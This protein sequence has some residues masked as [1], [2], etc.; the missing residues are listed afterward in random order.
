MKILAITQP[1]SGVGYHR[2]M[3]PLASMQGVKA[4]ATNLFTQEVVNEGYD[5]LYY[6]REAPIKESWDTVREDTG[7]KIAIDI[8]DH[9][10]L[11]PN[12]ILYRQYEAVKYRIINN[13]EQADIVTTTHEAL[14][15][16]IRQYNNNVVVLPNAIPYG[17]DLFNDYKQPSSKVRFF[18]AG[19]VT[20]EPDIALLRNVVKR[21]HGLP[22][23]MVI[24]GFRDERG[25]TKETWQRMFSMFTDG[26]TL[27]YRKIYGLPPKVYFEMFEYCDVKLVPLVNNQ[28]NGYKSN[29]KILEAAA[30][31]A[32]CIVSNVA[33]YSYDSE[34]PLL[35]VNNQKDWYKWIE[36][37]T[38]EKEARTEIGQQLF[39]WAKTKY[40]FDAINEQRKQALASLIKA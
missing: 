23:E 26:G 16:K 33:P 6:N 29:L 32:P 25:S 3:L 17:K 38:H 40:N 18:W 31:K 24:G 19:S 5:I 34:A 36:F 13:I 11:P 39:D 21:L 12:H 14:A 10:D 28:W 1:T 30:K 37:L 20:H 2:L 22:I 7:W 27:N 8:D 15:D 4:K 35:W 9:W